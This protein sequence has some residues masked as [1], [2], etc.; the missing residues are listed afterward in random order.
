MGKK[1]RLMDQFS[2]AESQ[3]QLDRVDRLVN[4]SW[5]TKDQKVKSDALAEMRGIMKFEVFVGFNET[6]KAIALWRTI[7]RR[8]LAVR[9]RGIVVGTRVRNPLVWNRTPGVVIE[10]RD[11]YVLKVLQDDE[12]QTT[13]SPHDVELMTS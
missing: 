12:S 13:M 11:D 7:S 8:K 1:V 4:E 10:I 5:R 2:L 3:E 6:Y 9:R